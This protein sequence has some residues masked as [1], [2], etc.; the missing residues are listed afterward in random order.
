[1]IFYTPFLTPCLPPVFLQRPPFHHLRHWVDKVSACLPLLLHINVPQIDMT[2]TLKWRTL[3]YNLQAAIKF[4]VTS[5]LA[6]SQLVFVYLFR[7]MHMQLGTHLTSFT[8]LLVCYCLLI[9]YISHVICLHTSV[10]H[11]CSY[12]HLCLLVAYDNCIICTKQTLS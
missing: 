8:A 9:F 11:V 1:M 5:A 3:M 12:A 2:L 6:G 7:F 10:M 4:S